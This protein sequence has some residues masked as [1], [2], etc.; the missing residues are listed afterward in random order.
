M[1]L[2]AVAPYSD[3][4]IRLAPAL[5]DEHVRSA[6]LYANR[7]SLVADLL[8][9]GAGGEI[10]AQ[11]GFFSGHLLRSVRPERLHLFDIDL[12]Q[13][14]PEVAGL[15]YAIADGTVVLHEGD[16]AELLTRLEE[17]SFDWLYIDGDHSLE[18]VRRDIA[19]A[20]H[21]LKPTGTLVFND[22]VKVS[23][24]EFVEYGIMEAVNELCLEREFELC[25]LAL[26]QLGYFDVAVRRR[27]K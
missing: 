17:A 9:G 15:D 12:S 8:S 3:V 6:R 19:A 2:E 1:E 26:H 23:P 24:L 4:P 14:E 13:L 11:A 5:R 16:S 10:G 7:H 27:F 21:V 20:L 22:Y 25:A 18:G